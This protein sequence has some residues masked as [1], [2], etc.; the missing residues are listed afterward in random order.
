LWNSTVVLINYDENDGFFDHIVPPTPPPGTPGEF[1]PAIE[2]GHSGFP[3]RSG[4]PAPI[5]LGPRVPMTVVSPW[6]RGGWVNSQVFDHTSVLRFLE[7]WTG[8]KEPNI[9]AWRRKIC[10]D[11]TSCFDFRAPDPTIPLLPDT[12]ALRARAD[13]T[14][15]KL[16]KPTVPALGTQAM[17]LQEQGTANA[18]PLPYQP[19]AWVSTAP[20]SL[21]LHLANHGTAAL[22][23][24]AY[25]YH[26][27]GASHR[28]DIDAGA[29]ATGEI[30]FTDAYDVVI[31]GPNGFLTAATGNS[32][33]AGLDASTELTGTPDTPTLTIKVTNARPD[34][35]TIT[36]TDRPEFTIPPNESLTFTLNPIPDA[37]G[38]YDVTLSLSG[39]PEWHRRFAGH[40]ENGHPSRTA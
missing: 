14:Q 33:T 37:H 20:T 3:H 19:V 40:L 25:A 5:G 24:A 11:L 2:P 9:S 39:H 35:A 16:P 31:H 1:L 4:P 8:V 12:T 34:P 18:R 13:Q 7:V 27:A 26:Q 22:Q 36:A 23:L 32:A 29:S 21:S 15:R 17:P 38:W 28:F 10:G 6:S 30:P